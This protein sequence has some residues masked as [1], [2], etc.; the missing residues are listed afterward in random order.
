M[1]IN[2]VGVDR[3]AQQQ[4]LEEANSSNDHDD[5]NAA[6]DY[7]SSNLKSESEN[8]NSKKKNKKGN[9]PIHGGEAQLMKIPMTLY[10]H[11]VAYAAACCLILF[12]LFALMWDLLRPSSTLEGMKILWIYGS[13]V[14]VYALV[15]GPVIAVYEYVYG[16]A[17]SQ[18][19]IF[20]SPMYLSLSVPCFFSYPT[21]FPGVLLCLV[22]MLNILADFVLK[23]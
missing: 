22:S 16:T 18:H 1:M 19:A 14:W 12:G 13:W 3:N 7:S 5:A 6:L 20:R 21:I 10:A 17:R 11:N 8:P 15:A 4:R 9:K 23:E 2:E